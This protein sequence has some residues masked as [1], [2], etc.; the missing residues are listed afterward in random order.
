[1]ASR[2]PA[3]IAE[4]VAWLQELLSAEP[5]PDG[6]ARHLVDLGCG[7]GLYAVPLARAGL[8]VTGIDFSPAAVVHARNL[9]M[10]NDLKTIDILEMDLLHLPHDLPQEL[11]PVD[12]I[13]FWFGE[14]NGF[15]PDQA[16]AMLKH[17]GR[18]LVSD[19]LLVLEYQPWDLF[20]REG[21]TSWEVTKDTAFADGRHLWLQEWSWDDEARAEITV[22]WILDPE[23]G[24]LD[25]H[26]QSHQAYTDEELIG[27]LG[28]AGFD[29]VSFHGPITG[30]DECFEFPMLVARR[31]G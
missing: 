1:M 11:A 10:S 9:A 5:L 3:V 28:K 26:A 25:R 15:Q 31:R 18:A 24:R 8:R 2:S 29:R 20:I 19:G 7:P 4:H 30:V 22:H 13:T 21:G 14:F 23:T 17:L 12:V 6:R 16:L 27:L